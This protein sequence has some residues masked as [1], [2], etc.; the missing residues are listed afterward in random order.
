[1]NG[2]CAKE[3]EEEMDDI[4]RDIKGEEEGFRTFRYK[5]AESAR[6]SYLKITGEL[7]HLPRYLPSSELLSSLSGKW[8]GLT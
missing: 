1:M 4:E 2:N 7:Y 3:K 6:R 5:C 8:A